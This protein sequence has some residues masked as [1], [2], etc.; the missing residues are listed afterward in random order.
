[1]D[2]YNFQHFNVNNLALY[3][4]GQLLH[5][6]A[7]T[8]N[9]TKGFYDRENYDIFEVT[10]QDNIDTCINITKKQF[11][12][13]NNTFS[14]RCQPDLVSGG[15]RGA[16]YMNP[17]KRGGLELHLKFDTALDKTKTALVY[18]DFDTLL[19]VSAERNAIYD[20]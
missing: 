1:M 17:Q 15:A 4:N 5:G 3:A 12:L 2:P 16:G 19:Q 7:K 18:M 13:G 8:P 20:F 14:F 9:F 6:F 11:P 10:N